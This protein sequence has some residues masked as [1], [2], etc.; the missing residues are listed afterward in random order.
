MV[1]KFLLYI[2]RKVFPILCADC[3]IKIARKFGFAH[4]MRSAGRKI[5]HKA[6]RAKHRLK[7]GIHHVRIHG[8]E[9]KVKVLVNGQWR[10]MK[11]K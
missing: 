6:H 1:S 10:F 8:K 7:A 2:K 9:R 5:K 11:G 3:K 4:K